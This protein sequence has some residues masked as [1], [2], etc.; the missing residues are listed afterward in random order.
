MKFY[1]SI[2]QYGNSIYHEY[3]DNGVPKRN[4]EKYRPKLGLTTNTE[5]GYKSIYGDNIS[6]FET[7]SLKDFEKIRKERRDNGLQGYYNDISPVFQYITENYT[8]DIQYDFSK[9]KILNL[10][11]EIYAPNGF[12]EWVT[13]ENPAYPINAITIHLHN[14]NRFILFALGEYTGENLDL[15]NV[16]ILNFKSETALL[17]KF[18]SVWSSYAPDI[19]T[20][21]NIGFFDIP[22]IVKRMDL[23]FD[24][25][26][27]TSSKLCRVGKPQFKG[28]NIKLRGVAELD[29][30]D[31]Y[32]KF[33]LVPRE[34][35]ALNFIARAELG[36]EKVD[37]DEVDNLADLYTKDPDKFFLYNIQDVNLV[38]ELENTLKLM[39]L[40][41]TVT[42]MMKC[43]FDDA[44]GTLRKWDSF[45]YTTLLKDNVI[46]S[47]TKNNE[48]EGYPGGFVAHPDI[49]M[50]DWIGV[51]DITSSYPFQIMCIN[52]SNDT[53][54]TDSEIPD[55]LKFLRDKYW[56]R[57]NEEE[58]YIINPANLDW[59]E[60]EETVVPL[61]RKYNL[62]MAANG[63]LYKRDFKGFLPKLMEDVFSRRKQAKTEMKSLEYGSEEYV[64]KDIVQLALKIV[65][66]S[67][68]GALANEFFRWYDVRLSSAI[69]TSGQLSVMGPAKYVEDKTNGLIKNVYSDTDSIFLSLDN[70]VKN[71]FDNGG[72]LD[73]GDVKGVADYL[74]DNTVPVLNNIIGEYYDKQVFMYNNVENKYNMEMELLS[75]SSIFLGKK[76]YVMV[77]V[78]EEGKWSDLDSP[79]ETRMKIR[80]MEIVRTS[81]P[82][83][84]RDEMKKTVGMIFDTKDNKIVSQE[85][86][87]FKKE[88]MEMSF[89]E[90]AFPRGV[91]GIKKYAS[92]TKSVPIHVRASLIHNKYLDRKELPYNKIADGD[93]IKFIYLKAGNP[94][95][96]NVVAFPKAPYKEVSD[97]I[98]ENIDRDL[99]WE[100][101]FLSPI[102]SI[103]E[104]I[105]FT[106]EPSRNL[107]SMF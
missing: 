107:L 96:S 24:D 48:K 95:G 77:K 62:S 91:K 85:V 103:F 32:K 83:V 84:I 11:I 100:K 89:K 27:R 39:Y 81:T 20:G 71:N 79:S 49:G 51:F 5:T 8:E 102:R 72:S 36:M 33:R 15:D 67:A 61:L 42:Y 16:T 60:I 58:D 93:K 23:I 31:L 88:F 26:Q 22:Y 59:D 75:N 99:Q 45:I 57:Q 98:E 9:L 13:N 106:L 35:Y 92:A 78:N 46:V 41:V 6:L 50:H 17:S 44:M 64:T 47:P 56:F 29:Y 82:Q 10:D 74:L 7:D 2:Y 70:V 63:T 34:S 30:I 68:Y 1:T 86:R 101:T 104:K 21:W 65:I 40:A 55:D 87:D 90:I 3:Y 43:T 53:L 37:Y 97:E 80:G 69:T 25:D 38:Y 73:S 52:I 28:S 94:L 12:S 105:G 54:V 4:V 14:E 66:N 18:A 19:I 76:K